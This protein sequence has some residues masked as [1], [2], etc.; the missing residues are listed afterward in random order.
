MH[1][2]KGLQPVRV[3]TRMMALLQLDQGLQCPAGRETGPSH[4]GWGPQDRSAVSARRRE[5][6]AL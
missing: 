6:G 1:A 2:E 5:R 4:A 3:T